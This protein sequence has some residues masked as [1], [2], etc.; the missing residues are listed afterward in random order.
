V[1]G[2]SLVTLGWRTV[3]TAA[4][5]VGSALGIPVLGGLLSAFYSGVLAPPLAKRTQEWMLILYE[6]LKDLEKRQK[7]SNLKI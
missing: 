5:L 4:T 1:A 3:S 7:A 2:R 6:R